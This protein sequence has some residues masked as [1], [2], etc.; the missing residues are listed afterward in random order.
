ML[1][2]LMLSLISYGQL[3]ITE[4]ADPNDNAAARYVEIYNVSNVPVDLT[5]WEIRRWT[6]GNAGPQGT[7]IDLTS[8]G[9]LGP[10]SFVLI[11]ANAAEFLTVYGVTADIDAGTAGAADSNGDDQIAIFDAADNT[12]DIFGVPGEDGTGTC[13]EFEDGRAERIATVSASNPVWDESEWNVWADSPV[14]GCTSHTQL[15]INAGDGVYDPGIWIGASS[16]TDPQIT[17]SPNDLTGFVQFV[18]LPSAE[19]TSEVS[20]SNLTSDVTATVSG[21]YEISLTTSTGFGPSVVFIQTAG[22]LTATMLYVRLNASAAASPSN[23]EI[24]LSST[25]ADNATITLLG[26]VLNPEA[27]LFSSEDTLIGFS[28]FVGA[29]SDEQTFDVSGNYLTDN[30]TIDVSG[31]FEISTQSMGAFS[32]SITL[33][34][35]AAA[36]N[37]IVETVG[38]TG[39]SP[40]TL[41]ITEGDTVT[42]VNT[43]GNH[44]VNGTTITFPSNPESFGNAVSSGWTFQHV[45]QTA[46]S[47]N[48][49]CD[50]HSGMGMTGSIIVAPASPGEVVSTPIYVR[51]N[52]AAQNL[53]QTG[54]VTV[55][56][57]TADVQSVY[58]FGETLDYAVYSIGAVTGNNVDGEPDS[59]GV[60]VELEGVVH[61]IDF[62]GNEGLSFTIIDSNNDGI[63]VFNFADV[64]AYVVNEGDMISVRGY[65][66]QYNGLTEIFADSILVVA[67]DMPTVAPTVVTAL[68]ESTESQWITIENL[69]FVTPIAAFPTGS[70][71][72]DVTDGTNV[73]TIRIDSD[74]DIPGSVT[75]LAPF[76][77]TG[78]GGQYDSS[79]PY[80][81]GYQL[82]PCGTGSFESSNTTRVDNPFIN[83]VSVF[84]NPFSNYLTIAFSEEVKC[85]MIIRDCHGRL[86]ENRMINNSMTLSTNKWSQGV[87]IISI[88]DF[89]GNSKI[90]KLIK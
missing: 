30:V 34:S 85:Q 26:E 27:V 51:L 44:N 31:E 55:S 61:C 75:P 22:E 58:L 28:H 43:G 17:A 78:V 82:F 6:N 48:Y 84:P 62:D 80:D 13:H 18:G 35:G 83:S 86:L 88:E 21:D 71:N 53:N 46:G 42:F 69:D 74:T 4:I 77:V 41:N 66:D 38:S 19:Q 89:S 45:F 54:I 39:F 24:V 16:G 9:S 64:S 14:T 29:P 20:G 32:N 37:Y 59:L 49:H 65:I 3:I 1:S 23:G 72:I 87:Y 81:E 76:K 36:Q 12:I 68:D 70:N 73:Y 40:S 15:P 2:F 7:G 25:G 67:A 5:D 47:Y 11:A 56:S 52:G 8:A 57:G 63:N 50:P 79:S 90:T 60:Y 33:V 10:N